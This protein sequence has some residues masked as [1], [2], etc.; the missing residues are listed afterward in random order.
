MK[1]RM[2]GTE[3]RS[4]FT[5]NQGPTICNDCISILDYWYREMF[6][7]IR[8]RHKA[9]TGSEMQEGG[10]LSGLEEYVDIRRTEFNRRR[11]K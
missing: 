3:N 8:T 4:D 11:K 9:Q 1:C 5:M 2:C 10:F 7:D 6:L